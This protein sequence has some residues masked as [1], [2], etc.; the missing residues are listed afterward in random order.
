[1]AFLSPHIRCLSK[2]Y[3]I[4]LITNGKTESLDA[5]INEKVSYRNIN[6]V[7]TVSVLSDLRTLIELW[8]IFRKERYSL[9]QSM[10]P[11][12][13]LLS[14]IAGLL[15]GVP[16]RIHYFTG[17]VWSNKKGVSRWIL[18]YMDKLLAACATHL[19]ADSASQKEFLISE[20]IV[21]SDRLTV[22]GSG[23]VSGVDT[24]RFKPNMKSRVKIRAKYAIADDDIVALYLGRL[25]RDKGLTE[26]ADAYLL[27][28]TVCTNLRLVIVGPD[29][30]DISAF[31]LDKL[32]TLSDRIILSGATDTPE[33]YMAAADYF[34]LPSYREG[35]G[36]TIIESA[37]CGIPAIGTKISGLTDAIVDGVTGVLVPR[38][39][40]NALSTAMIRLSKDKEFRCETG[41][42]ARERVEHEFRQEIYTAAFTEYYKQLMPLAHSRHET[43]I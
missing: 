28:A 29:E 17:Q 13:G 43:N 41:R 40:S 35:F 21:S 18:K 22:I 11:K 27:A 25:N 2:L 24:R 26:L 1:M 23:S 8:R 39:D 19:L 20:S 7:R 37:A 15:A 30:S 42:R 32:K 36:S 4:T 14:M 16:V 38:G 33:E 6:I 5:L 34:V 9:V 31:L 12:A 3:K 10:T